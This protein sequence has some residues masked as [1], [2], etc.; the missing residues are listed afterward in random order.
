MCYLT[1]IKS[2]IN[3]SIIQLRLNAFISHDLALSKIQGK[4]IMDSYLDIESSSMHAMDSDT[5]LI[6]T[7]DLD[8]VQIQRLLLSALNKTLC[9]ESDILKITE[10]EKYSRMGDLV[11]EAIRG[12]TL[13]ERNI[14]DFQQLHPTIRLF[15]SSLKSYSMTEF[16]VMDATVINRVLR[17][18][19][20]EAQSTAH[21]RQLRNFQRAASKNL[22]GSLAYVDHLFEHYSRLLVV[23]I[24]L[25]YQ[26]DIIRNKTISTAMTR[27]HRKRLFKRIHVHPLFE[28]C[29]GY[30]WKLE[31]GQRKGFHYH[32]CFFFDG[33]KV[34]GDIMLARRIGEFWKN[35]IT[36]GKGLY[37]NCN[38]IA[39]NYAHSGIG[40]IHYTNQEK[41]CALQKAI[42]YITKVDTAVRLVLPQ[43][44]RTFGRGECITQ[45]EKKRG[46]PRNSKYASSGI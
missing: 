41:R 13:L 28:N 16:S 25:S 36:E 10:G 9:S 3:I 33:S 37:F 26:K 17:Q 7:D 27:V 45:K 21:K 46:R 34:R 6:I 22:K 38:A 29:L 14:S 8:I 4:I 24:D 40:D 20:E 39:N 43:G 42:T 35:E 44:A 30:L 19:R 32:T 23:R 18:F 11:K 2:S 31:Y 15:S 5:K 12:I 1:N